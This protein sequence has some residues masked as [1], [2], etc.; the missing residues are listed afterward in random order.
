MDCDG[1]SLTGNTGE[2]LGADVLRALAAIDAAGMTKRPMAPTW[3]AGVTDMRAGHQLG[4]CATVS[5][6][7]ALHTQGGP[8]IGA[9]T[10]VRTTGTPVRLA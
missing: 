7:Y 5:T 6:S 8:R 3:A 2:E 1:I 9:G 10:S 4:A